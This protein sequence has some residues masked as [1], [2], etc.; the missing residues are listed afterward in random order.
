MLLMNS[1]Q[2]NALNQVGV[3]GEWIRV[4]DVSGNIAFYT[5]NHPFELKCFI[6]QILLSIFFVGS[7]MEGA[8]S[9]FSF[10]LHRDFL[11]MNQMHWY[12]WQI[13]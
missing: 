10:R 8:Y 6:M 12:R 1:Y 13:D 11:F 3:M 4:A 2:V 5:G 9:C 7:R